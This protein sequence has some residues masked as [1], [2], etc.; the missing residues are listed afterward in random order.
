MR[1]RPCVYSDAHIQALLPLTQ[2]YHLTLRS[3]G[4]YARIVHILMRH[5]CRAHVTGLH[6]QSQMDL[7]PSAPLRIA[8]LAHLP[9]A[10][11]VELD[12][13]AVRDQMQWLAAGR[14]G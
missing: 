2:M 5:R 1:G 6:V 9:F 3:G 8:V 11:A 4:Q 7:T 14:R 10:F 13:R 12:A